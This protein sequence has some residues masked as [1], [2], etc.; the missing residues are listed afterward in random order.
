MGLRQGRDAALELYSRLSA[1]ERFVTAFAPQLDIVI[2]FPRSRSVSLSC[3]R[4]RRIFDAAAANHLHLAM[5]EL[6]L[7]FFGPSLRAIEKD[8]ATNTV[9]CLRSVLMKPEHRE[10][11]PQIWSIL[12]RSTE[13]VLHAP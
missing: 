3:T 8:R 12:D 6:P 9:T 4:S 2:F 7:A 10:W 11:L 13:E 5:A 1:D